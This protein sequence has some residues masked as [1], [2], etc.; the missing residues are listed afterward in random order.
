[1][2]WGILNSKVFQVETKVIQQSA[3][4][5]YACILFDNYSKNFV[6]IAL[7]KPIQKEAW[8][9]LHFEIYQLLYT[10]AIDYC[11]HMA[12]DLQCDVILRSF[13]ISI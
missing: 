13:E 10:M 8:D 11:F 1:M 3:S 2:L 6:I 4:A 12:N 9:N 5:N 7:Y